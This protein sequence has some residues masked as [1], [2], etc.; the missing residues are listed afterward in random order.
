MVLNCHLEECDNQFE[1]KIFP[2]Q[3]VYPKYCP[4]HRNEYRR[5]RHLHAIGREDLIEAMKKES[6]TAEIET[7]LSSQTVKNNSRVLAKKIA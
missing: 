7:I 1:V 6:E 2:R 5:I 3:Y 4:E